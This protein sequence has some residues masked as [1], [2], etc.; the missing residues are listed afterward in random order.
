MGVQNGA[1]QIRSQ[2]LAGLSAIATGRQKPTEAFGDIGA[3]MKT[4]SQSIPKIDIPSAPVAATPQ[5][6]APVESKAAQLAKK[7]LGVKYT[8]GGTTAKGGFDCSGLLQTVWKQL[9][10][11]IPRVTYDQWK[12]GKPVDASQLK[13]GD[14]VF[15]HPGSRGPEH[16]GMYVGEGKF[17][18]A[19][20][21]GLNVRISSL[22][23]RSDYMGARRF[24]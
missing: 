22:A 6:Y 5:G 10:V 17:I 24:V 8:W 21:T 23:G 19:P 4:L 16:V 2:A 11:D 9:G 15:F 13:P 1:A 7:Y 3:L 14:A 20:R 18:E 12:S